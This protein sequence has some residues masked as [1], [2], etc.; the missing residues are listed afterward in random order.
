MMMH[1]QSLPKSS[2]KDGQNIRKRDVQPS[3]RMHWPYRD[4]LVTYNN[5]IFKGSKVIIPERLHS[6]ML[7]RT[8]QSHQRPEVCIRRE[9]DEIFWP[10]MASEIRHLVSQCSTC[11]IY[12]AQRQ[13]EPLMLPEIP[14]TPWNIVAQDLFTYA[15]RSYLITFNYYS[16]FWELDTVPDTSSDTVVKHSLC[17]LWHTRKSNH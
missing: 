13:K 7:Q 3:L 10:G 16:D 4:E 11:N 8:H 1:S 17:S 5:I 14:N 12:G 15:G 9:R 6:V 2:T